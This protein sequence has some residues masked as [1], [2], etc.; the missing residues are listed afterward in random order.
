MGDALPG[1]TN[2]HGIIGGIISENDYGNLQPTV[3][4]IDKTFID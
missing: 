3:A 2:V 4:H 1:I